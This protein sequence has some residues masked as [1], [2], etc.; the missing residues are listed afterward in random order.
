MIL[1]SLSWYDGS[2]NKFPANR[3]RV[4]I[5]LRSR[6]PD[7]SFQLKGVSEYTVIRDANHLASLSGSASARTRIRCDL[8]F[9]AR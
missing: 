5:S 9:G 8:S 4:A 7:R 2:L 3:F 6:Y 1:C